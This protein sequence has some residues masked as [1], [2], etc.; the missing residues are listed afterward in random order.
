[1]MIMDYEDKAAIVREII[2][3]NRYELKSI[4]NPGM[5]PNKTLYHALVYLIDLIDPIVKP[6]GR[7]FSDAFS[8]DFK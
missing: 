3:K 1:M 6:S 8:D 2:E 5:G 4:S 7:E